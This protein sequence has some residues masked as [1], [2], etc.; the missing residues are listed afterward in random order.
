MNLESRTTDS[1]DE[2]EALARELRLKG[3]MQVSAGQK[4]QPRQF[5]RTEWRGNE[6][7][8]DGPKHYCIEW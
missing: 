4:L 8:F 5:S 3:Y 6:Q 1:L 7:S 2:A